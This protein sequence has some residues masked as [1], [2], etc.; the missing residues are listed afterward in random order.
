VRK[1]AHLVRHLA[2]VERRITADRDGRPVSWHEATLRAEA[3]IAKAEKE[4]KEDGAYLPPAPSSLEEALSGDHAAEWSA[5]YEKE[6]TAIQEHGT[7]V[8]APEWRG[9]TVKSKFV[10]RVTREKEESGYVLKFKARLV[11]QGFS[12][13]HGIDYFDTFAPTIATRS[14]HMLL[15]IAAKEDLEIRHID[16]AGAYLES[17]LDTV[18]YM[19]LP[20]GMGGEERTVVRL[21]KALYGLKQSGERWYDHLSKIVMDLGFR[22]CHSDPCVFMK[23]EGPNR[24]YL[25]V[26]VD[27]ILVLGNLADCTSFEDDLRGRVTKIKTGEAL[28]YTGIEIQRDRIARTV[29]LSQCPFI[30]S[31]VEQEGML[32]ANPKGSPASSLTNYATMARGTEEPIWSAVGKVRYAVDHCRPEALYIASQLSSVA[33]APGPEHTKVVKRLMRYFAGTSHEGIT[34]GGPED[35]VLECWVDA[36]LVED[37]DSRSQ[38]GHCWRLN[39]K[40]G[41]C[42]S[43][44]TRDKHVS[45]SSAESELRAL[46]GALVDILWAREFLS[47]LG[48]EQKRRTKIYEDNQAVIDLM[49]TLKVNARTKHLTKILNFTRDHVRRRDIRMVKVATADNVADIFTKAL[50]LQVFIKH[51][52]VLLGMELLR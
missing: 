24:V 49:G 40:S 32:G 33:S 21:I 30:K 18:I 50:P 5:A 10:F 42:S 17:T 25:G 9:R 31:V 7:Y 37:G 2:G 43:K 19:T 27:D 41:F 38:L 36:S 4:R 8:P 28:R 45:L 48:Y 51:K 12:E 47:E 44:S 52:R 13:R 29:T 39:G 16:V 22:R 14:L 3:C 46:K 6:M 26:Y 35:I 1:R 15:H 20:K 23:G 11:A 34:L